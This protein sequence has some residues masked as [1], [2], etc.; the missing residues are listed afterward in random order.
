MAKYIN[1]YPSNVEYDADAAARKELQ[2]STI[3]KVGEE[4]RYDGVNVEV[5]IP[6]MGDAVYHD[7]EKK[8]HFIKYG[9]LIKEKLP[10]GYEGMG[11]CG[12]MRDASHIY[13]VA[14]EE[15]SYPGLAMATYPRWRVNGWNMDGAQHT[16]QVK[17]YN[18]G[19]PDFTYTVTAEQG[20]Q[21][22]SRQL[23][24]YLKANST[25]PKIFTAYVEDG[26][27][28]VQVIDSPTQTTALSMTGDAV[29]EDYTLEG[30]PWDSS[31][32]YI[33]INKKKVQWCVWNWR[34]YR[35]AY[36]LETDLSDSQYNP[37][38]V[39]TADNVPSTPACLPAYLGES[40]HTGGED[41]C[42]YLRSIH[43]E[44]KE[45]WEKYLADYLPIVPYNKGVCGVRNG[46]EITRLLGPKK[47][48]NDKGQ[49]VD[50]YPAAAHCYTYGYE[51]VKGFAPG[52]WFGPS[53]AE[54]VE[55]AQHW[56]LGTTDAGK[57]PDPI[58]DTLKA[59]SAPTLTVPSYSWVFARLGAPN[60]WSAG[61]GGG[62]GSHGSN[63]GFRVVP[64]GLYEL[65]SE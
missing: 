14:K 43:G 55:V 26:H 44:G 9:T 18:V 64:L 46:L 21:E 13:I 49:T 10:A 12:P 56:V 59:M 51:G 20:L 35:D 2:A 65:G 3:S 6:S 7:A 39:I 8:V 19:K 1:E 40:A 57:V 36:K 62:F 32:S 48:L 45:G 28:M 61:S 24:E 60:C 37:S 42:A 58:N 38:T 63:Y 47:V 22:C 5:K 34:R 52:D 27:V 41:R 30:L 17:L 11:V 25:D 31:G 15:R 29:S 54:F 50:L 53:P 33:K 4:L 16:S 23:N